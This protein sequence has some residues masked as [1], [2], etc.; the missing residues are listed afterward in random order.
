MSVSAAVQEARKAKQLERIEKKKGLKT[1]KDAANY[2]EWYANQP[3]Q[4]V[5][6]QKNATLQA[7]REALKVANETLEVAEITGEGLDEAKHAQAVATL[8]VERSQPGSRS[9]ASAGLSGA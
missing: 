1:A 7:N 6:A 2:A 4:L 8:V 5:R 3:M 9:P